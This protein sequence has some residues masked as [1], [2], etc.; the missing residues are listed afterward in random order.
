MTRRP[1]SRRQLLTTGAGAVLAAPA[2]FRAMPA[3]AQA[4]V[5]VALPS[6]Y[7]RPFGSGEILA[8]AD[9]YVTLPTQFVGGLTEAELLADQVAAYAPDPASITAPVTCHVIRTGGRVILIDSGAGTSFGPTTG[10]LAAGLAAAGIDPAS[11]T[12][13]LLTHLHPDHVGGLIPDGQIAFPNAAIHVDEAELAYWTD[14]SNATSAVD[15]VKPFFDVA[16]AAVSAYGE[17]I[18]PFG[19]SEILPGMRALPLP[20][21]T[22]AHVGFEV[23][24]GADILIVAGDAVVFAAF[25]FTHPQATSLADT[26]PAQAIET[27]RMLLDRAAVDRMVVAATHLPFP[28]FG[29]VEA[30]SDGA[31][32]WIPE[33]WRLG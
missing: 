10:R 18:Q 28:G 21:H 23:S 2:L 24:D 26:D 14:P 3:Q 8:I 16:A 33:N 32:A 6:I 17:R 11:V 13:I 27:R 30:R 12:D 31:Y 1:F 5:P 19:T 20:G 15:L 4:A 22:P 25:Q 29:H 9:G 7:P